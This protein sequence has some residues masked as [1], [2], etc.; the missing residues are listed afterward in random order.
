MH[1]WLL[2][3]LLFLLRTTVTST[4]TKASFQNRIALSFHSIINKF[5]LVL[6]RLNIW[7]PF[8]NLYLILRELS[9]FHLF[10]FYGF[11]MTMSN[12]FIESLIFLL[13]FLLMLFKLL[14]FEILVEIVSPFMVELGWIFKVSSLIKGGSLRSNSMVDNS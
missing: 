1:H 12:C 7:M 14:F 9:F 13:K 6:V 2:T 4:T 11:T 10:F 8:H 3:F 5:F